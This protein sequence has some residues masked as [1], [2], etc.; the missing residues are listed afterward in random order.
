MPAMA[1]VGLAGSTYKGEIDSRFVEATD[2][3]CYRSMQTF[4]KDPT[5]ARCGSHS[6][7][8]CVKEAPQP[9]PLA[10]RECQSIHV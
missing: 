3:G 6:V 8:H 7:S 9:S 4:S 10:S 5:Q 1:A 2:R